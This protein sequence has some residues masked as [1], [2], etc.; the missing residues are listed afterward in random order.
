MVGFTFYDNAAAFDAAVAHHT[1]PIHLIH[2]HSQLSYL[3]L[4]FRKEAVLLH[5]LLACLTYLLDQHP[6]LLLEPLN[7]PSGTLLL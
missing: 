4:L 7:G 5:D 6:F 3:F 1:L 2:N